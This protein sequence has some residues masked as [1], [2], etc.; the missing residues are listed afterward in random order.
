[1]I[2]LVDDQT[3]NKYMRAVPHKGLDEDGDESWLVKD[4]HQELKSWGHPGG[5]NNQLIPNNDG[6]PAIVALREALARCHGGRV[7]PEQPPRGELQANGLAEEAGR[8]VRDQDR[9]LNC[10]S[11]TAS[12]EKRFRTSP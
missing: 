11:R 9:G 4:M 1:M 2:V 3:G 12:V 5:G 7:T 6:E 8:T 10:I